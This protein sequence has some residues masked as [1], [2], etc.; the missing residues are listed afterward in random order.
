MLGSLKVYFVFLF[1]Y[2]LNRLMLRLENLVLTSERLLLS[3][4]NLIIYIRSNLED[5]VNMGGYVGKSNDAFI[6]R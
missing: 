4:L 1:S 6:A 2:V 5:K 3:G